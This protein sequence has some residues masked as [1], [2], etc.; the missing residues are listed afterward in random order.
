MDYKVV[1]TRGAEK[2][3]DRFIIYL[4]FEKKTEQAA[5]NRLLWGRI[6][7]ILPTE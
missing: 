3:I 7:A 1:L 2:D 5:E 4:L 6:C